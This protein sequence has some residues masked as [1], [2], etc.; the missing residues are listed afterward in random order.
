[1][2]WDKVAWA[3]DIF[4]NG[5]NRKANRALCAAVAQWIGAEDE[6]LECAC[7]TGLLSGVIAERCRR[8]VAT[9]FSAKMLQ[10]ARR[11][12][13]AYENVTFEEADILR[14]RYP[15]G[16]FDAVVAANVI[17]LLDEPY[18]ALREL[19]RVC[20]PGGTII[21][22]TYMN[23]TERGTTNRVSGAIG[24]AGANFKREF[25][26]GSYRQFFTDA[27]YADVCYKLCEGRIPCAVAVIRKP[28]ETAETEM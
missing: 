23:R 28:R 19:D 13:R 18:T 16:Q 14:L 9:D 27:G 2:F 1:M 24:K 4:A 5:I 22:P 10:Q 11:K 6:V 21:I 25:T 26:L 7:G 15:D 17:H 20:R 12:L 3:Y 8:L